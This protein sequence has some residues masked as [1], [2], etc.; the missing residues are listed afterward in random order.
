MFFGRHH[1]RGWLG[2]GQRGG[3][4]APNLH[5]DGV[6]TYCSRGLQRRSA[7]FVDEA[8]PICEGAVLCPGVG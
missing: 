6:G 4:R 3:E 8:W 5:N 1:V 2:R 7:M